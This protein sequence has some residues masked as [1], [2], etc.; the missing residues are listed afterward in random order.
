MAVDV[1]DLRRLTRP[2]IAAWLETVPNDELEGISE[3]IVR[4][5]GRWYLAIGDLTGNERTR[6]RKLAPG[7]G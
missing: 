7:V 4:K 5:T 3:R 1:P 2:E 6:R